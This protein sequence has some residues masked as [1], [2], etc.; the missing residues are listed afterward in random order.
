MLFN[1]KVLILMLVLGCCTHLF[2]QS[3][4]PDTEVVYTWKLTVED[5]LSE[6]VINT[7][8]KDRHGFIWCG[9]D[10]GLNR[11]DGYEFKIFNH[12]AD[13]SASLGNDKV[14]VVYIDRHDR[15]WVGTSN[16][17]LNLFNNHSQAF[18][19][20]IN[21]PLNENSISQ[22]SALT[23]VED[24]ASKLW[25]GTYFGLNIFDP[26]KKTF[27]RLF[28]DSGAT[29]IS[30]NTINVVMKD[31][32]G[33]IWVGTDKGFSIIDTN[34]R[35]KNYFKDQSGNSLE[36]VLSLCEG[37]GGD[38]WVGTNGNGAVR[39]NERSHTFYWYK[40][41]TD[42]VTSISGDII[43]K[44]TRDNYGKILLGTDGN[45]I[46]IYDAQKDAFKRMA[47]RND[48]SLLNAAIYDLFLDNENFLWIGTYGG[49]VKIYNSNPKYFEYYETFEAAVQ[50]FGKSSVLALAE[51][52]N[53]NIWIGTD[54]AGLYK[55]D[56][57]SKRFTSYLHDPKKKNSISSN[58]IKSLLVDV[59]GNI[60]AGTYNGGLNYINLTTN[61]I[62]TYVHDPGD[63]NSIATNNVWFL[64]QDSEKRIW[65]GNNSVGVDEF[66]P[67][68]G[69]FR[70]YEHIPD[71][72]TTLSSGVIF[73]IFE[74]RHNNLWF[75]TRDDG[76]N[77]L[78]KRTNTFTRYNLKD[79][80]KSNEIRDILED[81][82][83][84]LWVATT[85]GGLHY[86]DSSDAKFHLFNKRGYFEDDVLSILEDELGNFWIGTYN[87][88]VKLNPATGKMRRYDAADG[89][90][91]NEFNYGVKLKSST[92][93]LYFGGLNGFNSF[94]PDKIKETT[95]VPPIV[96]TGLK[97]FYKE[98]QVNDGTG[99]LQAPVTY[100]PQLT[101]NYDQN[102]ITI[103]YAALSYQFPKKNEYQ[104]ILEGFDKEWNYVGTQRSATYTNLP[105]GEYTFKVIGTNNEGL[106]NERGAT[107]QVTI[108]PPWYQVGWIQLCIA[109]GFAIMIGSLIKV[110]TKIL[111]KQKENLELLVRER[112][113][114][115]EQQKREIE[116]KNEE[117]ELQNEELVARNEEIVAQREEIE[118]KSLMLE[119]AHEEI[120]TVNDQLVKVNG[121]LEKLVELRTSE[122]KQAMQKLIETDEGLNMFLYRSSHDLRG[123]IT[124]LQGL[125][126]LAK[127]EN[128]QQ[129][130][131]HYFD[132]ILQSCEHMLRVLKKLNE[133][134]EVFRAITTSIYINWNDLI[135]EILNDLKKMDPA[136]EV[137]IVIENNV[138][139][140]VYSDPHLMNN[141]IHNLM[142]NAI[143]F[144][145]CV[146][147]YVKLSLWDK[148]EDLIIKVSDNGIGIGEDI[149][150][151]IFEMFFRGSEHSRG[152][153]LG[154]YLVKKSVELLGGNIE[155]VSN[156]QSATEV[157]VRIPLE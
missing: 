126:R 112:T 55:F 45:G 149:K 6:S 101:L 107:L 153:G 20:F 22:N 131:D 133:T 118:E 146:K 138:K 127:I 18:T 69:I 70:H 72:S 108:L 37:D 141:I 48:P 114:Q 62:T 43:R 99:I 102:V 86:Y 113:K 13:D 33:R 143:A 66:L 83:G 5:G 121:N 117:L 81:H 154:L 59:H 105:A 132:K 147:P 148:D 19:R 124:T 88:L 27:E 40:H 142:E 30:G 12:V 46:C 152:N 115:I 31:G 35:V 16:G 57:L 63:P 54:G 103:D 92:G 109:F 123:P 50:Q 136:N 25:I 2:G 75:G 8:A 104:Y 26:E 130:V 111:V 38:V 151:K 44:I 28:A 64:F 71:D 110:R 68:K 145:R 84:R 129:D 17:G 98:V 95:L 137:N 125:A 41:N 128:R 36:G 82:N 119:R 9:T 61:S 77:K 90:Q 58:V 106:W 42:D 156:V 122:L 4:G 1:Q 73:T 79:G 3:Y 67:E 11:Y 140:Q 60:Y 74:D 97:L 32:N 7:I 10:D 116:A 96:L 39:F 52:K 29:R 94:F 89:L 139:K 14:N 144:R 120:Q 76:L 23:I 80:L 47:S 157:T 93:A 78:N 34:R 134:N 24:D 91:G 15:M 87:G 100:Q 155:V 135:K 150:D 53:K 21:D 56:P 65:V 51:D 49:G 85:S